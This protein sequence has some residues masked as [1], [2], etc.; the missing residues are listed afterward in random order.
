V[1]ELRRWLA[2]AIAV[3]FASSL[4]GRAA[5]QQPLRVLVESID[6]STLVVTAGAEDGFSERDVL[7]VQ[8]GP[9]AAPIGRLTVVSTS[10][11]HARV[12]F[13]E[14]PF[15]ITLGDTLRVRL[16][17]P[18]GV[19]RAAVAQDAQ[20]VPGPLINGVLSFEVNGLRTT[21][22][23]VGADPV[24]VDR[25]FATPVLRLSA[26]VSRLPG[27]IELATRLRASQRFSSNDIVQPERAIRVYQAVARKAF[28][29]V[30]LE[31]QVGRFYNPYESFSGYWDG[32]LLRV[33]PRA[34]GVGVAVGYEPDLANQGISTNRP[35]YS[36]FATV[37][38]RGGAVRYGADVSVHLVRPTDL[39]PDR[40][41]AGLSQRLSVGKVH[42]TQSVQLDRDDAADTW[43]LSRL[44]LRASSG[45]GRN[46]NAYAGYSRRQPSFFGTALAPFS[47]RRD[48]ANVGLTLF[49]GSG[50]FGAD[51][52]VSEVEGGERYYAYSPSLT[53]PRTA[54]LGIGLSAFGTYWTAGDR[55]GYMAAPSLA[56]SFGRVRTRAGYQYYRSEDTRS[57]IVSHAV[58]AMIAF[59]LSRAVEGSLRA[60]L[61]RGENLRSTGIYGGVRLRF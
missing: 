50:S 19:P 23:G 57:V 6:G 2:T 29:A 59:P 35:K 40:T 45:L 20:A 9:R 61:G 15:P 52:T 13:A 10:A 14:R 36:A 46:L 4:A 1:S 54:L 37:Q 18:R 17:E 34:V 16:V 5:A 11:R 38:H 48:R 58:D 53:F 26:T 8:R 24:R 7:E 30:P 41:Y 55:K 21:T 39:L 32:A 27:G 3:L 44:D 51:V 42:L 43:K 49:A 31:I 25:D 22:I 28:T 33:G 47:L 56:R 60:L 12:T